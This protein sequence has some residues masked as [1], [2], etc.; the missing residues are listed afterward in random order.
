MSKLRLVW[1]EHCGRPDCD[2]GTRMV[3]RG[4]DKLPARCP[5][6]RRFN[7][8]AGMHTERAALTARLDE[9]ERRI[10]AAEVDVPPWITGPVRR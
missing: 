2:P 6:V 1:P 5:C 7:D 10:G 9:L 4:D 3:E 8:L